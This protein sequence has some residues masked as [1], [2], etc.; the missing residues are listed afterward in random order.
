MSEKI[1]VLVDS[2]SDLPE[3]LKNKYGITT[4]DLR[5]IYQDKAYADSTEIT[6][7]MV[8]NRFPKEIPTTSA[9]NV[10]ETCDVLEQ[11]HSQGFRKVIS[12][13]I[14]SGLSCT[15]QTV[16]NAA[17]EFPDMD[18]FVFDSKNISIGTGFYALWAARAI[19]QGMS[20]EQITSALKNGQYASKVF[21]Y[22]DTLD[23]LRAGGRIGRVTGLIGKVLNIRPIISCNDEGTY[24]TA[25]MVRGKKDGSG[26]MLESVGK[27]A[28]NQKVWLALMNGEAASQAHILRD[29]LPAFFP[30][31][32]VVVEKQINASM[33]VHT[34]P[35]LVGVGVFRAV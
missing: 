11:L 27:L 33:A 28:T 5:V 29:R 23:Y 20:F 13:C 31:G 7:Q 35:G 30:N 18:I 2:G 9:P 14:S 1:A 24:Y 22:M 16:Q 21:F 17:K 32:K 26:R 3:D 19:Q 10:Q 8:Y 15:F 12:I 25:A 4:M 34:G 6:P